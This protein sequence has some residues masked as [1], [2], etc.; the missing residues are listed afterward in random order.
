[1]SG[2]A[3]LGAQAELVAVGEASGGVD[4]YRSRVHLI[5]EL[6]GGEVVVGDDGLGVAGAVG[7]DE[8]HRL[9]KAA[10]H[11]D[12]QNIVAEL[13][14]PV[15]LGGR[16][17][18]AAQDGPGL[19]AA[20]QLYVLGLEQLPGHG[21][22]VSGHRTVH[23]QALGGVAHRGAGGLGVMDD[24][25]GH[26]QVGLPVD[27]HV[28]HAHAGLDHRHLGVFHHIFNE[29]GAATGNK[30][31]QIGGQVHQLRQLP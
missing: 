8:L 14:V 7:V 24:A 29:T 27:V 9:V 1:M 3:D 10:H 30:H 23:Q 17:H 13:G 28:A 21:Q 31:I 22:E 5:Q 12:G 15:L 16:D 4:I 11:L 19:G 25:G 6:L 26:V 2:D 20:P 18:E